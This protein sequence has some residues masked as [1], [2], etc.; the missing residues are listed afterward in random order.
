MWLATSTPV[1]AQA[2]YTSGHG[3][4]GVGY[5]SVNEAFEPHW[6]MDAGAVI[7][8]SP[9]VAGEEYEPDALMARASATRTSPTGLSNILGVS[10]GTTSL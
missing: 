2:I 4:I 3:D 8:G 9:L 1:I 5:D 6:H 7:D 10:D